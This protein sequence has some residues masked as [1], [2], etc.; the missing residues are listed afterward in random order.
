MPSRG[1]CFTLITNYIIPYQMLGVGLEQ[2]V[3]LSVIKIRI[4]LQLAYTAESIG[5]RPEEGNPSEN[6]RLFDEVEHH[7]YMF[8]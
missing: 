3:H 4:S 7:E 8:H 2:S 1:E 5:C 6:P